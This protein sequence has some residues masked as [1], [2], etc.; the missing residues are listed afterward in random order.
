MLLQT[1]SEL[2]VER[3]PGDRKKHHTPCRL[4][5]TKGVEEVAE[6]VDVKWR[7]CPARQS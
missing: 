5:P 3:Q 6:G 4:Q 2:F 1:V 7:R